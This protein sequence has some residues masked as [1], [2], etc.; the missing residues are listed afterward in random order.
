MTAGLSVADA[1]LAAG[2]DPRDPVP[3]PEL[4]RIQISE[5]A[6]WLRTRTNRNKRPFQDATVT[7]Y[8]DAARSLDRW[9]TGEDLDGDFT[10]CDTGLLNRFFTS[11]VTAHGQTGLN[12]RQ[13]NLR[14]LFTWL[15]EAYGH[16][17]PYTAAL[18]RYAP[19]KKRPSTLAQEF[20]ADLLEVTGG[21]R[22]R[23]FEDA[24]DHAMIRMLTEGVRRMELIQLELPDLS[25]DLIA[26]PF[27]RVVPLKSA[28]A[29]TEGRIVPL[30]A[31]TSRSVAAYLRIRRSHRLAASSP[32]LWLGTRNRGPLTGSGLYRMLKRRAEQAG[33][34]PDVHPHQF[35]HTF[36][37]DWLAGDGA[38]G[39]LMRL[40]GWTDRSMLD[41]Y[42]ED[43]QLQRAIAAKRRRGDL[44]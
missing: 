32:A 27:V 21:G 23:G 43:M 17:H 2:R 25:A 19:L 39:D 28:R 37:N 8:T 14:H 35:R 16:P 11:W 26:R 4:R 3:P 20:I 30:T 38:E 6:A 13:R 41:L 10:A 18:H 44:Y 1:L 12:T 24:R 29:F 36:A 34:E 15:E 31:A 9:M 42:A 7:A 22:A 5:F 33:Y 40:M